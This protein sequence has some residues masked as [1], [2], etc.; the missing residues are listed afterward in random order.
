MTTAVAATPAKTFRDLISTDNYK[1]QIAAA[2]PKGLTA[3]R[4]TRV[5]LTAINR[6]PTLLDCTKESMW[7]AVLDCAALGLFP[8]ALGRAY[9]VPYAKTCQLIIGYKGLIDLMYRS[10]RIDMIQVGAVHQG[11]RWVYERGMNP[12][13][14]HTPCDK[15]GELTHVYTLV[16]LKGCGMPSIEVMT[17]REVD[18]IRARSRS[19][20]NGPWKTDYEAMAVKTCIRKHSKVLPM[21]SELAAALDTDANHDPIDPNAAANVPAGRF[22]ESFGGTT[23]DATAE[24][25]ATVADVNTAYQRASAATSEEQA[26]A[27][28]NK[29]VGTDDAAVGEIPEE[30]RAA[31]VQALNDLAGV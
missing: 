19:G 24:R 1:S 10:D 30:R 4:M 31:V 26:R 16:H 2:L 5:V 12:K 17:K 7:Q 22:A 21:S 20:N 9:L 6:N 8:D 3:E 18:A 27:A 23:T 13:L 25:V 28:Y 15:P 29:S 11:D 14:E